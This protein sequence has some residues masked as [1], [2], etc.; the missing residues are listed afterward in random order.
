MGASPS[1]GTS[2]EL[3]PPSPQ[4]IRCWHCSLP[5]ASPSRA[6]CLSLGPCLCLGPRSQPPACAG[7]GAPSLC[8]PWWHSLAS[9]VPYLLGTLCQLESCC[10][11]PTGH[12]RG[13]STAQGALSS[14]GAQ[15]EL[16]SQPDKGLF[17]PATVGLAPRGR[18]WPLLPCCRVSGAEMGA[19]GTG[20]TA[21]WFGNESRGTQGWVWGWHGDECWAGKGSANLVKPVG[22]VWGRGWHGGGP[23]PD[24]GCLGACPGQW[25]CT[26]S[27]GA[28]LTSAGGSRQSCGLAMGCTTSRWSTPAATR[29]CCWMRSAAVS[30]WAPRTTSSL[31]PWTTSASGAGR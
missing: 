29:P 19:E 21:E 9:A 27:G 6:T 14:G 28:G 13:S 3:L 8:A 1:S 15:Q 25:R 22:Q 12:S 24:P 31:W 10:H 30:S 11:V 16:S 20:I 4:A 7:T 26:G 17:V 18:E 2:P 5:D 23:R